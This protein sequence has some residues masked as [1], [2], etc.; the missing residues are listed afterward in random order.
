MEETFHFDGFVFFSERLGFLVF[1]TVSSSGG[2]KS[3][4]VL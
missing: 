2:S 4:L 1:S 3:S